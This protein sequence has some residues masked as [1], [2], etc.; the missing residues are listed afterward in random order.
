VDLDVGPVGQIV[1]SDCVRWGPVTAWPL[2]YANRIVDLELAAAPHAGVRQRP[3]PPLR[4]NYDDLAALTRSACKRAGLTRL[5]FHALRA[6]YATL[7]AD[8][9]CRCRRCPRC[10]ATL[11]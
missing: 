3:A 4:E 1:D 6:T 5:T 9:A 10:S 7:V 2:R 11:R 8:Q